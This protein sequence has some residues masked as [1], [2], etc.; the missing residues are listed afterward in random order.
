MARPKESALKKSMAPSAV[1][2][3]A[4]KKP[5]S[6]KP[7]LKQPAPQK[8]ALKKVAAKQPAPKQPA[9]KKAAAKTATPQE[10]RPIKT[11]R[12]GARTFNPLTYM[13]AEELS[14]VDK[15]FALTLAGVASLLFWTGVERDHAQRWG[16]Q[17]NLKTLTSA[18]GPLMDAGNPASP[19]AQKSKKAYVRYI[20][21][22]SGRFAQY[23]REHCRAVVLTNPPPDIYSSR[24]DNT[25]QSLEE[26]ILK[27]L[28]G[29]PP[30][31]RID[32]V[33]PTVDGA[34]H[35]LYQAWPCNKTDDW[36]IAFGKKNV[37]KWKRLNWSYKSIVTT[38]QL[39]LK[40]LQEQILL[41]NASIL[42]VLTP[43][44]ITHPED[45]IVNTLSRSDDVPELMTGG[46][47]V[48]HIVAEEGD[49][50]KPQHAVDF[51]ER[52]WRSPSPDIQGHDKGV[53]ANEPGQVEPA[54]SGSRLVDTQIN[55]HLD[56]R[57]DFHERERFREL[58]TPPAPVYVTKKCRKPMLP[59]TLPV[60]CID[61]IAMGA[62]VTMNIDEHGTKKEFLYLTMKLM[63]GVEKWW[64]MSWT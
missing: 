1:T 45:M 49:V 37:N 61:D 27:G 21:G 4:P 34:A 10:A 42:Q 9:A 3:S 64:K 8:P 17:W 32:Y 47:N 60:I 55:A 25:Y 14:Q 28:F 16:D 44:L 52:D 26:P 56:Q 53:F 15:Q 11:S 13:T 35:V 40:L 54:I 48:E 6:Q 5:A 57:M 63:S 23:A 30:V 51:M 36:V 2:S 19:K 7:A 29:D 12:D 31:R 20:K 50:S 22:A 58:D 33:H 43:K 59:I 39:D 18:M 41:P 62:E 46:T 38:S 24:E